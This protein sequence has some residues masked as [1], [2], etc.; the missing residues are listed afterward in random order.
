MMMPPSP[1]LAEVVLVELLVVL[2]MGQPPGVALLA[3]APPKAEAPRTHLQSPAQVHLLLADSH[4]KV[5]K[6]GVAKVV[7]QVVKASLHKPF[8]PQCEEILH[9]RTNQGSPMH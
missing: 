7:S 5:A 9:A 4:P 6:L 1:L 2:S 8:H 3:L